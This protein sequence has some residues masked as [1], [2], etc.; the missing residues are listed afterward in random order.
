MQENEKRIALKYGTAVV[1]KDVKPEVI[2][3]LRKLEELAYNHVSESLRVSDVSERLPIY[4]QCS[5]CNSIQINGVGS[6]CCGGFW[7]HM[8]EH[9]VEELGINPTATRNKGLKADGR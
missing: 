6:S 4:T 1:S 7:E 2:E 3:S 9:E 8:Y 5:I